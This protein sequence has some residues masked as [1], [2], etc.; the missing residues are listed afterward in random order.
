MGGDVAANAR[1]PDGDGIDANFQLSQAS[2]GRA[3]GR[4]SGTWLCTGSRQRA[5]MLA[6]NEPELGDLQQVWIGERLPTVFA[7][8]DVENALA[9]PEAEVVVG[10]DGTVGLSRW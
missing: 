10:G 2:P 7:E 1:V 8:L 3:S 6:G 9:E 5:V 4:R